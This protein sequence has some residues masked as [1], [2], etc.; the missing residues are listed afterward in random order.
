[1]ADEK[2]LG[3]PGR[4]HELDPI[5]AH[6][7]SNAYGRAGGPIFL[8]S[9]MS[10]VRPGFEVTG[11]KRNYQNAVFDVQSILRQCRCRLGLN[12]GTQ[13]PFHLCKV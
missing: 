10:W 5:V 2:K 9:S 12:N 8:R 13:R 3:T 7:L 11:R 1:M 4:K 6:C